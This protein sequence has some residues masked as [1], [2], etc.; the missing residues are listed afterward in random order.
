MSETCH[1]IDWTPEQLK[2]IKTESDA[3]I[4]DLKRDLRRQLYG[5]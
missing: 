3:V 1:G 2:L 4:A 5:K